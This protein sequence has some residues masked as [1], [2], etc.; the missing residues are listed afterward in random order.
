MQ[1]RQDKLC[2]FDVILFL[3]YRNRIERKEG[4]VDLYSVITLIAV[5]MLELLSAA[6]S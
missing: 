3:K 6:Q 2:R 1:N 5:L 4:D